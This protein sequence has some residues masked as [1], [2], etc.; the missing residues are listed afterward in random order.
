MDSSS[1][2]FENQGL[3]NFERVRSE[4]LKSNCKDNGAKNARASSG[5]EVRAISLDVETIVEKVFSQTGNGH[6]PHPVSLPQMIDI[7][8]DFWEADGLYE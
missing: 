6:L 5:G 7:L 3:S 2:K 1:K 8:I 4:W